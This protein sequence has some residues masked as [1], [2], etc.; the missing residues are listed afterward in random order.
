M[1]D[2]QIH[3]HLNIS[4]LHGY[5]APTFCQV[6]ARLRRAQAEESSSL[7]ELCAGESLQNVSSASE[8][9]KVTSAA[10]TTHTVRDT[11]LLSKLQRQRSCLWCP[12]SP[13]KHTEQNKTLQD[14]LSENAQAVKTERGTR[15]TGQ[16]RQE[17]FSAHGLRVPFSVRSQRD[18][19]TASGP[20]EL[21]QIPSTPW[22]P[23]F[24]ELSGGKE[25][26]I[27]VLWNFTEPSEAMSH[28]AWA[29]SLPG[30]VS[31]GF[32][33][34]YHLPLAAATGP[35]VSFLCLSFELSSSGL[36]MWGNRGR[37]SWGFVVQ[38]K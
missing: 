36:G 6:Y 28:L 3:H 26:A 19:L 12:L 4:P 1:R 38:E 10:T 11:G 30:P 34:L 17:R 29:L 23:S 18:A 31:V 5:R 24:L 35:D 25:G 13:L 7:T 21:G 22:G 2:D 15:R 37:G 32:P 16:E 27:S 9:T 8:E 20:K 33:F 14:V